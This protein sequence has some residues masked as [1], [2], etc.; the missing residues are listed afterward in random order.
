MDRLSGS[1]SMRAAELHIRKATRSVYEAS[2]RQQQHVYISPSTPRKKRQ[3]L[4]QQCA[5]GRAATGS[6]RLNVTAFLRID[7]CQSCG[8]ERPWEWIPPV[9][10]GAQT[11]AGTGV[12]R[13]TLVSGW[14]PRCV[15]AKEQAAQR[16]AREAARATEFARLFGVRAAREF[17]LEGYRS[18]AGTRVA[19]ERIS[20]FDPSRENLYL[21]G[22]PGVGKTH[23]AV[24]AAQRA[25]A[26]SLSVS[27]FTPAQL[28]RRLRMRAPDEEQQ[29]IDRCIHADVL[30]IDE[31]GTG[32]DSPYFRQIFQEIVD[33]RNSRDRGGLL[34]T[35]LLS[36]ATYRGRTGDIANASRLQGIC[37]V[38]EVRGMDQRGIP[39]AS[40]APSR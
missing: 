18:A 25:H 20:A 34:L 37:A 26:R 24:A 7:R 27:V 38:I 28:I 9:V 10:I 6:E 16:D 30:L 13:G 35:S 19:F 3:H 32:A 22:P 15:Q 4:E 11:L 40:L 1:L 21:W 5:R 14:C 12:W 31:F 33:G 36:V 2:L 17:T 29:V 23:L 8:D 39:K